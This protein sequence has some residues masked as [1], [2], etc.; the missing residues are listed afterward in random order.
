[1]PNDVSS[2]EIVEAREQTT[3]SPPPPQA[4]QPPP[5]PPQPVSRRRLRW[6]L[7]AVPIVALIVGFIAYTQGGA[8]M[9][10]D[11]AYVEADKVGLSTDVSGM[12]KSVEVQDNQNVRLG[13]VLF[14][15]DPEPFQ[16]KLDGANTQLGIVRD[17]LN[18]LKANYQN[19]Q[20]QITQAQEQIA[21]TQR[22]FDRS[23][24][25]A[26]KGFAP[27]STLDQDRVNLQSAR[28][29]LQSLQAQ[30]AGVVANLSGNP[31]IA[32]EQH[33]RYRQA[34]AQ[35][36]EA[37]RELRDTVVTAPFNGIVTNVPSLQPGMY[38]A[39]STTAFYLVRTDLVWV[40]AE[41]KETELTYVRPGQPVTVTVDTFP[42]RT[43]HGSVNSIGPAAQ[44]EFS[45]LP[46]QN[47]SGNWV[48]VVQRIPLRVTIATTDPNMP[49][50]SAGMSAEVSIETGHKRGWPQFLTALFGRHQQPA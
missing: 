17:D 12:V 45:L 26:T 9:T 50:L 43:W 20:A 28:Q 8:V 25:L 29:Q 24:A 35:K 30:L 6:A 33:P 31:D 48:K 23:Q 2:P 42:G 21:F 47:T 38:L 27:Q 15:L 19:I 44:S 10:T 36:E 11:D 3:Q 46:A 32:I 41:P 7:Y 16:L 40:E 49:P 5:Q 1:M 14:R 34:L 22:Q 37:A 4:A 39:A 18:A 13:Q